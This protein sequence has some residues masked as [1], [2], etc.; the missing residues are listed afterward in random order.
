MAPPT[1]PR[2]HGTISS[3]AGSTVKDPCHCDKCR[4]AWRV[5]I[6]HYRHGVRRNGDKKV[7]PMLEE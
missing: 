5:Y 4:E 3:Y 6:T 1:K 7:H 2:K